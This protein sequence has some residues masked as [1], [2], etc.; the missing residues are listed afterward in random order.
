[1]YDVSIDLLIRWN[2]IVDPKKLYP[3]QRLVVKK[4]APRAKP[5]TQQ[6]KEI[7]PLE[8]ISSVQKEEDNEEEED[9]S[10]NDVEES[11]D[12]DEEQGDNEIEDTEVTEENLVRDGGVAVDESEEV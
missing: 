1:M 8:S 12:E 10:E 9:E 2:H 5:K 6:I 11:N 3:G 4:G 7:Q